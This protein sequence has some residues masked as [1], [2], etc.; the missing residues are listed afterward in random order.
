MTAFRESANGAQCREAVSKPP[1]VLA[2]FQ[3]FQSYLETS[4]L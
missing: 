3:R 2:V 1:K 4:A